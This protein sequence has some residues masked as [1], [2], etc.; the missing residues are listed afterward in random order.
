MTDD[1][2]Q[3]LVEAAERAGF[4]ALAPAEL[5][6]LR[7]WRKGVAAQL[8]DSKL[9][10]APTE[11]NRVRGAL[12]VWLSVRSNDVD[13]H[14]ANRFHLVGAYI[15]GALDWAGRKV[16]ANLIFQRCF[17]DG[18]LVL[19]D[20]ETR[21]IDL[22]GSRIGMDPFRD[23][24]IDGRHV[25]INGTF[26]LRDVVCAGGVALAGA[27]IGGD[28]DISGSRFGKRQTSF[29]GYQFEVSIGA[30]NA[31]VRGAFNMLRPPPE[32]KMFSGVLNLHNAEVDVLQDEPSC[33][34]DKGKLFLNG[35]R[36]RQIGSIK[37]GATDAKDRGRWLL[38]QPEHELGSD[39]KPQPFEQLGRVLRLT[40]H[41]TDARRIGVLKQRM[42]RRAGKIP[43]YMR[44]LHWL[45]GAVVGYGYWTS[46][47]MLWIA[48]VVTLGSGVFQSAWRDG[49][50]TPADPEMLLS[51]AWAECVA[52]APIHTA[53]CFREK[54]PGD[55]YEPFNATLY[56]L[57][58]FLPLV[59]LEQEMAWSPAIHRGPETLGVTTGGWA[60]GYRFFHELLGWILTGFA[61][62]GFTKLAERD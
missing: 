20:A 13:A 18:H 16:Q 57:D 35:F 60:W 21:S 2:D 4:G 46:R 8:G 15:D 61:A 28:L 30:P 37:P 62:V 5:K 26:R 27:Q 32:G 33:W 41:A 34:P 7:A 6:M 48:I 10:E 52:S 1:P 44:P 25:E 9:P 56:S 50:M 29:H 19:A 47:V 59:Q 3:R 39:F 17:F 54:S 23:T 12:V 55:D 53:Q 38:L 40:G 45:F 24:S 49:A 42:L 31:R 51:E 58:V 11:K 43:T 22:G 36:Y 14:P